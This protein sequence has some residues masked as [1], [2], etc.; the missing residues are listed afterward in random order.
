MIQVD[1]GKNKFDLIISIEIF[2]YL[3]DETYA[4]WGNYNITQWKDQLGIEQNYVDLDSFVSDQALEDE[5]EEEGH[6]ACN[7]SIEKIEDDL[8]YISGFVKDI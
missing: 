5:F 8:I 6:C 1:L 4:D 3:W 7:C 2:Q